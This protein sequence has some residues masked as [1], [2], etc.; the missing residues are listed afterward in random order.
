MYTNLYN[1]RTR[2]KV[3]QSKLSELSKVSQSQISKIEKGLTSSPAHDKL[4]RIAEALN[5]TIDDLRDESENLETQPIFSTLTNSGAAVFIPLFNE[6]QTMNQEFEKGD[7]FVV[8]QLS[9]TQTQIRKPSF[10]DYSDEA[11]AAT[12]YGASMEPRYFTG[13]ILFIDPKLDA[14]SKD[15]VV[16]MFRLP[17]RMAGIFREFVSQTDDQIVIK[18]VASNKPVTLNKA[19]I[20]ALHVVVGS[21]R[22][23]AGA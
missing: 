13:D 20:Y 14:Q 6:R 18:D 22:N 1:V 15:D 17:D 7:G 11:Y 10:L 21:Q 16:V 23:R 2:L 4:V 8:R 5:C 9:A 3:S 12:N 19:D